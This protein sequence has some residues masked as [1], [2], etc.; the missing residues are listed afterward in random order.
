MEPQKLI[1]L[2]KTASQLKQNTRH[3]WLANG[4]QES[5]AALLEIVS[6]CLFYKG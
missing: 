4:R 2:L 6:F 3:S 1:N 5:V